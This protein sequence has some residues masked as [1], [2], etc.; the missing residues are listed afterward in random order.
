MINDLL[1]PQLL[2]LEGFVTNLDDLAGMAFGCIYA[3]PPWAYNN[4]ATRAAT[5]NHYD[6]TL[7]VSQL[8]EM[9]IKDLAKDRS[10]LH[11]WV[12][13]AFLFEVPRILDAWGFE[14]RSTFVWVKP[15]MGIGNYWR[16][17][18]ELMIT[19]IRGRQRSVSKSEISWLQAKRTKHSQKP[20][21]VRSRIER[22]SPGP[23]LELFG[24]SPMPGWVVF[25]NQ[26]MS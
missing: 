13:N 4:Q 5:R 12:T 6:D 19:A 14:Y 2:S 1:S 23:Y 21:E 16:N 20:Q 18:H 10:H 17:A 3:D 8:C 22:L 15:Q 11:L 9:P 24:R 26:I 7:T 25:G